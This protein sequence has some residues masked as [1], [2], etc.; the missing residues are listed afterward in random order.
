MKQIP[1]GMTNKLRD[2]MTNKYGMTNKKAS[3]PG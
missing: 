1:L 3:L 2:G